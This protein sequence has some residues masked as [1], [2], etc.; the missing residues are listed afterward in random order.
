MVCGRQTS[1][2]ARKLSSLV[3]APVTD[4]QGYQMVQLRSF[5][6]KTAA[7]RPSSKQRVMQLPRGGEMLAGSVFC[8]QREGN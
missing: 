2:A 7:S 1:P 6:V 5:G 3:R 4:S 8:K